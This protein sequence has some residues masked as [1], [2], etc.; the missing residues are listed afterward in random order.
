MCNSNLF[1]AP[2]ARR[3]TSGTSSSR[4]LLARRI[5][6]FAPSTYNYKVVGLLHNE[7]GTY[8]HITVRFCNTQEECEDT[9]NTTLCKQTYV[10]VYWESKWE[11]FTQKQIVVGW[12]F[13]KINPS[14]VG[15]YIE[16]IV[17]VKKTLYFCIP[18]IRES[19]LRSCIRTML[20]RPLY[21]RRALSFLRMIMYSLV[22]TSGF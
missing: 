21:E 13:Q 15:G 5:S 20:P 22:C 6:G 4:Y 17:R 12:Q 14:P 9:V 8:S 19:S 18:T 7:D 3:R 2:P 1:I 16:R 10:Q 11:T